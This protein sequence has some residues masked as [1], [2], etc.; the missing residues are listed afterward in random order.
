V[1][2]IDEFT[3]DAGFIMVDRTDPY[4]SLTLG[5]QTSKTSVKDDAGGKNVVF[6][7]VMS[8]HKEK[9]GNELMVRNALNGS[10]HILYILHH[11]YALYIC[12]HVHMKKII[13]IYMYT[14]KTCLYAHIYI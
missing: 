7:E 10:T 4:V 8:F 1:V 5:K 6:N 14:Y 12:I 2:K 9:T 3:D 13:Y 11:M